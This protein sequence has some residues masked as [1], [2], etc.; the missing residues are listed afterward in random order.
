MM[1]S[2][3]L[4]SADLRSTSSDTLAMLMNPDVI[5][6][7]QDQAGVQGNAVRQDAS[8]QLQVW[9]KRLTTKGTWAVAL[10]NRGD[11]DAPITFNWSDIGMKSSRATV[12]DL[13][14]GAPV[15][16]LAHGYSAVV[17]SHGTVL[18]KVTS[19]DP[20]LEH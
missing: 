1:A 11:S 16:T 12:K 6:V 3:L 2:P 8:G 7:D 5:A 9:A 10:F 15:P 4:V 18:L 17:P 19:G 20:K 13:W 14:A